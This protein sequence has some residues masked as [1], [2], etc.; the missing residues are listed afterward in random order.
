MN[1]GRIVG[2]ALLMVGIGV[3]GYA[4]NATEAPVEQL[5][6]TLTGRYRDSTMWYFAVGGA[7]VIGGGLLALFGNR[8]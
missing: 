2:I 7:A 8:G 5:S 4:F 6:N 1:S 3:V